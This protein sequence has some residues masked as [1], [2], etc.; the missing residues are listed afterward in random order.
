MKRINYKIDKAESRIAWMGKRVTGSHHGTI[1]ITEGVLTMDDGALA[2]GEFIVDTRSI[3]ILDITDPDTN[4]QFAGHLASEDFFASGDYPTAN[5]MISKVSKHVNTNYHIAAELT[6]KGITKPIAFD[7]EVEKLNIDTL[8]ASGKLLIDRTKYNM[9]F[10]SGQFFK[11]LGDALI[12][13]EFTLN[14]QLTARSS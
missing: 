6:I 13:D 2:A 7:A 1:D 9:K 11:D 14:V 10:R 3:K 4:Q 8:K 12:Y 5:L